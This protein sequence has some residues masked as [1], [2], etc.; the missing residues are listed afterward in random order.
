MAAH[1]E[2]RERE[3]VRSFFGDR[4]GFFVEVGANDPLNSSQ[5]WHLEQCG[6]RGILIEPHPDLAATL[7]ATRQSPIYEFACS[8]PENRGKRLPLH[9]HGAMSSLD[10]EA[11]APGALPHAT[12]SVSVLTLDDILAN[13]GAPTPLDLLS[14]DVEGHELDVLRGFDIGKWRPRLLLLEDHVRDLTKHRYMTRRGYRLVRRTG[15]NAWYVPDDCP[16]QFG[17]DDTFEVIRKYYLALPFRMLRNA[18]RALRQ[19]MKDRHRS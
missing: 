3:L 12:V 11:M 16:V 18:S 9:V 14:I 15:F 2:D 1:D 19:P 17:W 4:T 7:R 5:S 8:A 6:W 10:R 13:A